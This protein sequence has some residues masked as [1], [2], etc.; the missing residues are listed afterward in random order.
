MC[1]H[2]RVLLNW[3]E[4]TLPVLGYGWRLEFARQK[5]F[6][7]FLLLLLED[8]GLDPLDVGNSIGAQWGAKVTGGNGIYWT[9]A[10][11]AHEYPY[12]GIGQIVFSNTG[13]FRSFIEHAIPYVTIPD[14]FLEFSPGNTVR[15]FTR[16]TKGAL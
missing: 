16:S 1:A 7:H 9:A 2:R 6:Q 4:R 3:L 15:T 5:G 12:R 14:A 10:A 11:H 8:I 13:S